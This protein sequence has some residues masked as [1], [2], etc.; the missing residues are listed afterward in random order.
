[1]PYEIDD[2]LLPF[3]F[4]DNGLN[5]PEVEVDEFGNR[6]STYKI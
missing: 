2:D 5:Q 4:V 1:M 3:G 6:W